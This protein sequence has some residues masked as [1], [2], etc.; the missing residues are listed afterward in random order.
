MLIERSKIELN[1]LAFKC[2]KKEMVNKIGE[3]VCQ[4]SNCLFGEEIEKRNE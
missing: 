1:L 2:M 4:K 3:S